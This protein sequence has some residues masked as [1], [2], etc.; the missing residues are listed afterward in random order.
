M[1]TGGELF[2]MMI[3]KTNEMSKEHFLSDQENRIE[4]IRH[5]YDRWIKSKA[6]QGLI[7]HRAREK[8]VLL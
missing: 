7:G 3:I 2:N 8:W 6:M 1:V 5:S 4:G